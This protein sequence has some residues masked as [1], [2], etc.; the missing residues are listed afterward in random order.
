MLSYGELY[1]VW[2]ARLA[3]LSPDGCFSRM[4]NMTMLV[5]GLFK[6]RSVHLTW[7]A[8]KLPIRAK[9]LSLDKRLRRFWETRLS[10]FG[11]GIALLLV[12]CCKLPRVLGKFIWLSTVAK[13]ALGING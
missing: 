10:T 8:R 12:A 7:V 2:R 5:I 13:W 9:K 1:H 11:N 6:A 4:V 3:K